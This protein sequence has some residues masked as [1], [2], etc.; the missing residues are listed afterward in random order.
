[1]LLSLVFGR[2]LVLVTA[3]IAAQKE[4]VFCYA[5]GLQHLLFFQE[6]CVTSVLSSHSGE[7]L[8]ELSFFSYFYS[9]NFPS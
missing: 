5:D 3:E 8:H 1:M 7:L 9:Y 2:I 4:K 6:W